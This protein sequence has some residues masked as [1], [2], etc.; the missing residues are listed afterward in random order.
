MRNV[1]VY[2][3]FAVRDFA[4]REHKPAGKRPAGSGRGRNKNAYWTRRARG[5]KNWS[6]PNYVDQSGY[7]E[8]RRV[9]RESVRLA[10]HERWECPDTTSRL[11]GRFTASWFWCLIE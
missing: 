10:A 2:V 4:P 9:G 1:A 5:N 6:A 8:G 3:A 11:T 7:L